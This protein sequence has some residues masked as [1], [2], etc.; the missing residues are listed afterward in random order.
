MSAIMNVQSDITV[1]KYVASFGLHMTIAAILAPS[2]HLAEST[3]KN[4]D[5]SDAI[6]SGSDHSI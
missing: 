4:H 5:V 2:W 1:N 3:V 6:R